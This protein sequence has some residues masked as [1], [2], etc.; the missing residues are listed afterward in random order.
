MSGRRYVTSMRHDQ[1]PDAGPLDPP[2]QDEDRSRCR[3]DESCLCINCRPDAWAREE[4]EAE[5]TDHCRNCRRADH[6]CVCQRLKNDGVHV[7]QPSERERREHGRRHV[8][9]HP[10]D[11]GALLEQ[12]AV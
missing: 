12:R 9:L 11:D 1:L 4:Y 10:N 6:L 5:K 8:D 3:Q 7:E 2:D